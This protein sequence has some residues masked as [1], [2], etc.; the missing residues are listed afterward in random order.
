MKNETM[1][2]IR[3]YC[4]KHKINIW[5]I[6]GIIVC[7]T[8]GRMGNQHNL[9]LIS[10]LVLFGW[11]CVF[12]VNN[13]K[14][15]YLQCVMMFSFFLFLIDRPLI[16]FLRGYAWWEAYPS[17]IHTVLTMIAI[18]LVTFWGG[19]LF[20]KRT[21]NK[22]S[23]NICKNK[24]DIFNNALVKCGT[25]VAYI[26]AIGC[27]CYV[28][29]RQYVELRNQ[30]YTAMYL[31]LNLKFPF[32][33][34]VL[35]GISFFLLA[36]VLSYNF[37]KIKSFLFLALYVLSGSFDFLLGNRTSLM[38]KILFAVIYYCIRHF[39]TDRKEVWFGKI[40]KTLIY[41]MIPI[42]I[43]GL[44]IMNYSRS[45]ESIEQQSVVGIIS[46]FFYKQGTTFDTVCQGISLTEQLREE[47]NLYTLGPIQDYLN[48]ST[49]GQVIFG[50]TPIPDGNN[51]I[52]AKKGHDLSHHLSYHVLGEKYL[53]GH[54]RGSSF[55]L[56]I[57]MDFGYIG[58]VIGGFLLGVFCTKVKELCKNQY[59]YVVT[60]IVLTEL[61]M[62][63]RSSALGIFMFIV[64]PQF[65]VMWVLLITLYIINQITVKISYRKQG[66]IRKY[67]LEE[68]RKD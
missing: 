57:Y 61:F 1:T 13:I 15:Y 53:E 2:K 20:A 36:V 8:L 52:R 9:E 37:S 63:T 47:N 48:D 45:D 22:K 14:E 34:S 24:I 56:E 33:V 6:S 38:A 40:E 62:I 49:L 4:E 66:K 55:I 23:L 42:S 30:D 60:L 7:F 46:D 29:F 50:T 19:S 12:F 27:K 35:S 39:A 68:K 21:A 67:S 41:V 65:W 51:G 3:D 28:E 43:I 44:G 11:M 10:I 16:G 18:L 5:C 17:A 26:L 25:V 64:Q 31:G 32:Y 59:L 58:L 54:G